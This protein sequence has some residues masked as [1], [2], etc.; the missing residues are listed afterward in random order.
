MKQIFVLIS[1][2]LLLSG[3]LASVALAANESPICTNPE[4]H[5]TNVDADASSSADMES[6]IDTDTLCDS[7]TV[8]DGDGSIDTNEEVLLT[9]N[10]SIHNN[11]QLISD[12][13]ESSGTAI[14][15][16]YNPVPDGFD[17][18][19]SV[20]SFTIPDD[21]S[22]TFNMNCNDTDFTQLHNY[23]DSICIYGTVEKDNVFYTLSMSVTWDFSTV[24]AETPGIYTAVGTVFIPEEATMIDSLENT[25]SISV[26]VVSPALTIIPSTITITSFDEPERMDAVA[27][28][29]GTSQEELSK[30]FADSVAGF[31]GYDAQ[32][33]PYN[34]VSGTWS[35]ETVD[36]NTTGIYYVSA[37][38]DLGTEYVLADG[39]SLPKQLCAVSI[40]TP[41]EPDIN[42]CVSAR[43]FLR[44]PWVIS[45]KQQEQFDSFAVWLRQTNGEWTQLSEGFWFTSSDLQL[46][47]HIFEYGNT[48]DLKVTYPG[49]ETGVLT[50]QYDGQLSIVDYSVGDRDGGDTNGNNSSNG[51]QPAPTPI[52]E[53]P[54]KNDNHHKDD[55]D[56]DNSPAQGNSSST[57]NRKPPDLVSAPQESQDE[58]IPIFNESEKKYDS[59]PR[60]IQLEQTTLTDKTVSLTPANP[61]IL[62]PI[63]CNVSFSHELESATVTPDTKIHMGSQQKNSVIAA[64]NALPSGTDM[65]SEAALES[66]KSV[67]TVSEFYSP[68]Q[69]VISGLRLKNLCTEEKTVVFGSGNLTVSIPSNLL[70]ALN[71]SDSDTISIRLTQP[72]NNQI[73]FEVEAAGKLV[74]ELPGT[75]LR[76]RYMPQS[77]NAE[78]TVQNKKN[79]LI[80]D[81]AYDGELLR[82]TADAAGTYTI[83]EI[84]KTK[85][86]QKSMSPLLLVSSG[87]ILVAGAITF[88][89]RKHNE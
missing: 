78:I 2:V 68:T 11:T 51:S 88:F 18:T 40:Q 52:P 26:Q 58:L 25:I 73:L 83:L 3:T 71:L 14:Q 33:N 42:C 56:D 87:L 28:A 60:E 10:E 44:F 31:T 79:E 48:Y 34:L 16:E 5:D 76:F 57:S 30:W 24:D 77:E 32:G 13:E 9:E 67:A 39:I 41:G 21:Y 61:T 15:T 12:S 4:T 35:L 27:F 29:I 59:S 72:E 63:Y 7:N 17:Y 45:A 80:M 54:Q 84:S 85:E 36:T 6:N 20:I 22:D 46:T 81:A 82:F 43:G 55:D 62:T 37:S 64:M 47:Q 53:Q 69:T 23:L 89:W 65:H 75:V 86:V 19:D 49:D 1:T 66:Q 50:F 74:T 38:P 8:T 70:L